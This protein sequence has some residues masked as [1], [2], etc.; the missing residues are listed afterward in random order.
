MKPNENAS[1]TP[2]AIIGIGAMFPRSPD[3]KGYWRL[4]FR[5]EDAVTEVP[6]S[7]WSA[8]DYFDP[9]PNKPDHVY[10]SRGGYLSAVPFD[11]TEFGLPPAILE[12]TDT[13]QLLGLIVAK[14]ALDDAGYGDGTVFDRNRT[15]VILGVTGTQELVVPLG[16]RL[17]HPIW[18]RAL[19]E[20]GVSSEKTDAV[21]EKIAASYVSWQENSFPGLLGNVVAGRISNRLDLGG[22]NCAVDAACA[23]SLSALH[24]AMMELA[25]GRSDMALS[26]GVDT[27]NDIFMHMC[28][29][30]TGVLSKSGDV[31]PFSAGADGTV[32]G[33][34]VGIVALKRLADARK[35]GDRIYAVIRALGTASDGRSQS[36][37][38][39]R[40]EGQMLALKRAYQEAGV[41]PRTVGLVEAHG[42]GTRVGDAVEFKALKKT[43][44]PHG[45]GLACTL[46]SVKSM[47]GHTKAAAGSAGLIKAALALYHKV[48][49]P[50][51]KADPVDPNLDI[52]NSRFYLSDQA[53]PWI[54]TGGHPRR[55]GVSSFGFGG[56][57]Y[58]A[59][60]EEATPE[61]TEPAWDGTCE[62]I[63]FSGAEPDAVSRQAAEFCRRVSESRRPEE[64]TRRAAVD[65]RTRFSA[66]SRMRLLAVADPRQD[67]AD[68]LEKIRSAAARMAEDPDFLHLSTE[69]I[70]AGGPTAPPGKLAVLFPGQGSQYP[71]MGLELVCLFPEAF[72]AVSRFSGFETAEKP[73]ASLLYPR[74]KDD[75]AAE[76]LRPTDIAQPAIGAVSLAMW[77]VLERFGVSAD[78]FAGHSFGEL[79][80]LCAAG[81]LDE[82]RFSELAWTRGRLM[83][84]AGAGSDPGTMFAVRAPIA[85]IEALVE[86]WSPE[87]VLANRNA[88]EQGVLSGPE[89]IVAE[90]EETCRKKGWRTV[91]VPV[92]AAFHSA[93][94]AGAARP[95]LKAV[96]KAPLTPGRIPV[97]SNT[98]AGRYPQDAKAAGRL[99]G[100]QIAH[101]VDFVGEIDA[102]CESG[103]RVFLEVGPG[104]VL[105][106]LARA[107][108]AE[109]PA[110]VLTL[111]AAA[112]KPGG[113]VLDLART[114]CRL[115]ALGFSVD[116]TRWESQPRKARIPKM[117]IPIS[118]ANLKQ[119]TSPRKE[120]PTSQPIP[121]HVPVRPSHPQ[122]GS[123]ANEPAEASAHARTNQPQ[124]KTNRPMSN[125]NPV[126]NN[127]PSG[128]QNAF[129]VLQ[130]GL[131]SMQALQE[132]TARAHEKFLDIQAEAARNLQRLIENS[133]GV[134]KRTPMAE[135][136]Q[137]AMYQPSPR[138]EGTADRPEPEHDGPPVEPRSPE[139]APDPE[140]PAETE[141]AGHQPSGSAP[142]LLSKDRT[143]IEQTLLAVVSELTGYPAEMIEGGMDIEADL[144]IDSIKRVEILSTV[145]E[146]MPGLPQVTPDMMGTLRTL[147][148][149]AEFLAGEEG[150]AAAPPDNTCRAPG[151]C[152]QAGAAPS[153]KETGR[154]RETLLAVVSELTGYPAEMIEGDMDIEADLGIDSIKRV[155]ILSTVEERM[156]GLPQVTPDMMGTLRTLNQIAEFLAGEEGS[157]AAQAP[158][159]TAQTGTCAK[160]EA[161][162]PTAP[163][164][165]RTV[166]MVERARYSSDTPPKPAKGRKIYVTRDRSGLSA[167]VCT[168]FSQTGLSAKEVSLSEP[169]TDFSDAAGLVIVAD[170]ECGDGAA[171]LKHALLAASAAGKFLAPS[172]AEGF[173]VFAGISRIDG[174]F[175]FSGAG[176]FDP[177]VGGLAGLVKCA[178]VEWPKVFC[179]AI[180]ID[181]SW[182]KTT[183]IAKKVVEEILSGDDETEVGLSEKGRMAVGL[184]PAPFS[185]GAPDAAEFTE[186]DV[187]L[188][189]G[190]GRGVTA[191]AAVAL[192]KRFGS[193]LI[194]LGRTPAPGKEPS[195]LEGL[196]EAPEIK[197]AL[198]QYRFS[199]RRPLPA[200]LESAYR[201]IAAAR[202]IANTIAR[203][204]NSGARVRYFPADVRDASM[205][206]SILEEV[207]T[208][209]GPVTAVVH[210]AGVLEDRLIVEK[211]AEQFDR[212][213]STKV[214]GILSVLEATAK[215]PVRA[216]VLFSSVA[217]RFGNRGQAD[218]AM[219]N[220]VLNKIAQ[221]EAANRPGCRVCAVNW[222]PWDGG[223]VSSAL[224][225]EFARRGIDLISPEAGAAFLVRELT[226]PPEDPVEIVAGASIE[227]AK[228]DPAP[229]AAGGDLTLTLAKEFDV[230]GWPVFGSH[231]LDGKPVVPFALMADWLGH[232]ALKENP[233]LSL[234]GLDDIRVLKGIRLDA[235]KRLVRL[236]S[237]KAA[238]KED[239]FLADVEIRDGVHDGTEVVHYRARAVLSERPIQP[240]AFTLPV[241]AD[242][243]PYHRSVEDAYRK[244]LFHGSHLQGIRR[245]LAFSSSGMRAELSSAPSPERWIKEPPYERWVLDPLVLD[246]A[247]QMSTIW[248]CE[249]FGKPSLPS[250]GASYRQYRAFPESGITAVLQINET[251][252]KRVKGDFSFVDAERNLIARLTGYEAVM[253]PS[254]IAAFKPEKA[255]A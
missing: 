210:G 43:L 119:Q 95:F 87:L 19:E 183:S 215:D 92:A 17:G 42:T 22:T 197:K 219:A 105:S 132:Q 12:A 96:G 136:T 45:G 116:L 53:R 222:G 97:Y 94:V 224:K 38:A 36:I 68:M 31:K 175:G 214:R 41:D 131:R 129:R 118:G 23:S 165:R 171:M 21:M 113:G 251:S 6:D 170:S 206:A 153:D 187:V 205:L 195:W 117:E 44:D 5:A 58:H 4:L 85:E 7:H 249:R 14:M 63:A 177:L 232:G 223:M 65:S 98:T 186:E 230:E 124:Q 54:E 100:E 254:L 227:A 60:L 196:T 76:R 112:G 163:L 150:S 168:A 247:F 73:L 48:L 238:K 130:E 86:K 234:I 188:V 233:G 101:P 67:P 134:A 244:F 236:L 49:P 35:D 83:A 176:Q 143:L 74:I 3:L 185:E 147:N 167:A 141:G 200:E 75:R 18:R 78:A 218:Y 52:E 40:V 107:N 155:E 135:A 108:L 104:R 79:T 191:E 55:A 217:A 32:L 208:F 160:P 172:A 34:G 138:R 114:L 2:V 25:A 90:A 228:E 225:R 239:L 154:I 235:K 8:R 248:C 91:R 156:P 242:E 245:I 29:S 174:A 139:A 246:C 82:D 64:E 220:E 240:P 231:V 51:L 211:T 103:C 151:P 193:A 28:F 152:L 9:D 30:R 71:D 123:D 59:V 61:K 126:K 212:V 88:P 252:E 158:A 1:C 121:A 192:A 184:R 190:G 169:E 80:A 148:Q 161:A 47:I 202:E 69:D 10:C 209:Y 26:G 39:P 13:S 178:A 201:E 56:S 164:I 84:A 250:Y 77:R 180:D 109:K 16:A 20:A 93:L 221:K 115:A 194:L 162:A 27:L 181:P 106:G 237:G 159:A 72:R 253:D 62:I 50:T 226:A 229:A 207:R 216:I 203:I 11:P 120:P 137:P 81:W 241:F 111:D 204:E 149:I 166:S 133:Q 142:A 15:S 243:A 173:C 57:N 102:L 70:F 46:G 189:T 255:P 110:S 179:K 146:R 182:T 66:A 199:A 99:L 33:E 144:G 37:Y 89:A 198:L 145:E 157:A 128:L 127:P 125:D 140:L 24:L 213:F 122:H